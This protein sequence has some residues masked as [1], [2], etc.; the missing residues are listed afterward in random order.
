M[1]DESGESEIRKRAAWLLVMLALVA[2]LFAVLMITVLGGNKGGT[3]HTALKDPITFA[4][5][6]PADAPPAITKPH[7]PAAHGSAEGSSSGGPATGTSSTSTGPAPHSCP[8]TAPC[9]LDGDIGNAIAAVNAYRAQHGKTPVPGIVSAAAQ[10]CALSNG[11]DCSGGWAESQVAS[12]GR[13]GRARQGAE[14]RARHRHDE[15]LRDRLGLRP[16]RTPVLLRHR[17]D[18]LTGSAK[19]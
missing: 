3:P 5:R 8:T 15:V 1:S 12:P 13:A 4:V 17:P 16:G 14:L 19:V 11:S 6:G 7:P 2:G 9:A 18:R 10:K